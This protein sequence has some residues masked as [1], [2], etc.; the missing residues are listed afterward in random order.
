MATFICQQRVSP[1][2]SKVTAF[3]PLKVLRADTRA[4]ALNCHKLFCRVPQQTK[5]FFSFPLCYA[6]NC[7]SHYVVVSLSHTQMN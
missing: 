1:P 2:F 3:S 6:H 5:L 4:R 7:P